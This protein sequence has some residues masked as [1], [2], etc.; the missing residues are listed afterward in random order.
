MKRLIAI[1]IFLIFSF[2]V[3]LNTV[4][5]LR[6]TSVYCKDVFPGNCTQGGCDEESGWWATRCTIKCSSHTQITCEKPQAI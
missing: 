3:C 4:S 5:L 1:L 2:L 6:A